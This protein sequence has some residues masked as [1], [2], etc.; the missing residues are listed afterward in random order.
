MPENGPTKSR[1]AKDIKGP[2]IAAET[3]A[4]KGLKEG[5]LT[6][7]GCGKT[8]FFEKPDAPRCPECGGTHFKVD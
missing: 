8:N 5:E 7:L 1:D 2:G 6:C 4:E 3:D